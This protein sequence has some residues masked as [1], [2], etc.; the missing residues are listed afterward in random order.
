MA[1]RGRLEII[2]DILTIIRDSHSI[3]FTPLLRK[4][5]LSSLRFKEYLSEI[6]TKK[7]VIETIDKKNEKF[8]SLTEKGASFLEQYRTIISFIEEFEL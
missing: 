3:K 5:N 7:F 4:A 1:K 2:R 6:M 8:V